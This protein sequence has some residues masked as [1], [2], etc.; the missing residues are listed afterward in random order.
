MGPC[1]ALPFLLRAH[2]PP[3]GVR[4]PPYVLGR[5][6]VRVGFP[7]TWRALSPNQ[8]LYSVPSGRLRRHVYTAEVVG[9]WAGAI[10][11]CA[12][13]RQFGGLWM[14][15]KRR[16]YPKGPFNRPLALPTLVAI[17]VHDARPRSG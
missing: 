1:H 5:P 2:G 6:G 17:D 8:E 13:Y 16:V 9:G 3:V 11:L 10:H 4:G 7:P 14:P 12:D 15:T